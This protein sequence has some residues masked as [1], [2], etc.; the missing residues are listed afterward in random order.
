MNTDMLIFSTRKGQ[1][2]TKDCLLE[3][4][5]SYVL[6]LFKIISKFNK[7]QGK[8]TR[9]KMFKI[10]VKNKTTLMDSPLSFRWLPTTPCSAQPLPSPWATNPM[11]S[12]GVTGV[13][14]S[15]G[16]RGSAVICCFDSTSD[17]LRKFRPCSLEA[18]VVTSF[19]SDAEALSP[20]K[21]FSVLPLM[22][23]TAWSYE[24]E[25]FS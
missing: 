9:I 13:W 24:N 5:W 19:E 20:Y 14:F 2:I 17:S 23:S 11:S 15:T 7:I 10:L 6:H 16:G 21:R 12:T 25:I 4:I 3:A 18:N 22:V 8:M 1:A